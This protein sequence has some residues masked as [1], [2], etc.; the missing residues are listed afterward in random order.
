M[1][2]LRLYLFGGA[3]LLVIYIA[4]QFNTPKATNWSAT[5]INSKTTP[6]GTYVTYNRIKDIFPKASVLARRQQMADVLP[7]EEST[8]NAYIII[9]G[10]M[11]PNED[12]ITSLK[13]FAAAGNNVFIAAESFGNTLRDSLGAACELYEDEDAKVEYINFTNPHLDAE[14]QYHIDKD[15]ITNYF[16]ELDTARTVA[17]GLN[18]NRR[19]NLVRIKVGKGN[20]YLSANPKMFTNYSVLKSQ[21]ASYSSTALSYLGSPKKIIWDEFYTQG[22]ASLNSPLRFLLENEPLRNAW[23]ITL[24]GVIAFAIYELKRRQRIIPVIPP[25]ANTSLEF[26]NV[27]GN[28]YF[29]R[30]DN[31]DI[32]FKKIHYFLSDVRERYFMKTNRIDEE[33]IELLAKKSGIEQ[34]FI[35][36]M[37]NYMNYIFAQT[38]VTDQELIE[39][40]KLIEKFNTLSA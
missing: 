26:V 4:L 13:D 40:N 10:F 7:Y 6:F 2:S 20:I 21:G 18:S 1:K 35:R 15:A 19:A 14:R 37:A 29:E 24:F 39:L 9:C 17:L 33:F 3:L 34:S 11:Q 5:Y 23:Y 25:V 27:V 32:A 31:L 38:S 36:G 30:H 16:T 8:G 28:V 22:S 12:D